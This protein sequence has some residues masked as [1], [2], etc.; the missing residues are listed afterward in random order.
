KN[1][2]WGNVGVVAGGE[3]IVNRAITMIGGTRVSAGSSH[4]TS[5]ERSSNYAW[6]YNGTNGGLY[7]NFKNYSYSVRPITAF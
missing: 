5:S 4:W 1:V 2:T 7:I 3:D 6:I